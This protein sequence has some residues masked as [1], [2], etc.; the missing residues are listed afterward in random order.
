M[1]DEVR[2]LLSA[3]YDG[4]LAPGEA[5][6]VQAHLAQC[7]ECRRELGSL[8]ELSAF[9]GSVPV[10]TSEPAEHFVSGVMLRLPRRRPQAVRHSLLRAAWWSVPLLL[11]LGWALL[12]AVLFT[13]ALVIAAIRFGLG[14]DLLTG[15]LPGGN[16]VADGLLRLLP[17]LA[18]RDAG[19]L[20][21]S[22]LAPLAILA[23][24]LSL[25][26]LITGALVYWSWLASWQTRTT[27][28]TH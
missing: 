10:P 11:L 7:P 25:V 8:S 1:R 4:E 16:A 27:L 24:V 6:R 15:A 20:L 26:L 14:G 17:S 12:Q 19:A 28:P 9:L 5:R 3:Y 2:S 18:E 23:P 22:A 13:S 21:G